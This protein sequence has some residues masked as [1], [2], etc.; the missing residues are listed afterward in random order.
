M[1]AQGA[2]HRLRVMETPDT[3][4]EILRQ[5][6]QRDRDGTIAGKYADD[7]HLLQAKSDAESADRKHNSFEVA[8]GKMSRKELASI[9]D[10]YNRFDL[11]QGGTLP[12]SVI[13][14]VLRGVSQT[15][16][17][18]NP[19]AEEDR[20]M[21][22][23]SYTP[24][25][26]RGRFEFD[27]VVMFVSVNM[28]GILREGEEKKQEP[29]RVPP[30]APPPVFVYESLRRP[31]SNSHD[32]NL[33]WTQSWFSC[34]VPSAS[35]GNTDPCANFG[36]AE[37]VYDMDEM[38]DDEPTP[39]LAGPGDCQIEQEPDAE[40]AAGPEVT[41]E[42]TPPPAPASPIVPRLSAEGTT[43]SRRWP[44]LDERVKDGTAKCGEVKEEEVPGVPECKGEPGEEEGAKV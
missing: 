42:V 2:A 40:D 11:E 43:A 38:Y 16:R 7:P 19:G 29:V 25:R 35:C 13:H 14:S 15:A 12:I 41:P 10:N 37:A 4:A 17:L 6:Q 30:K 27:E 33:D 3:F 22:L 18:K 36:E 9:R 26:R 21:L 24:V 28:V 20:E 23:K 39:E 44:G 1:L 5:H 8:K 34:A 31:R 32:A